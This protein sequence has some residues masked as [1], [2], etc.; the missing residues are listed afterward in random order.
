MRPMRRIFRLALPA[1]LAL[2]VALTGCANDPDPGDVT[3]EWVH[4]EVIHGDTTLVRTLSGSVWGDTMILVPEVVIGELDGADPYV[5][6]NVTSVDRDAQGRIW[7]ADRQ[8]GE[9][10]VF[11]P[12]GD[13]L[14]VVGSRGDGPGEYQEPD[15]LRVTSSDEVVVRDQR[16]GRFVV[17][18]TE[19]AYL[20]SWRLSGNFVTMAPFTLDAQDRIYNP[21]LRWGTDIADENRNVLV[22]IDVATGEALD[23]LSTPRAEA[24]PAFVE[25]RIEEGENRMISRSNVPFYPT[26][27]ASLTADGG[28]LIG[29][30]S[31]YALQL[32]R[33]DGSVL[34][35]ERAIEPVPV[36]PAEASAARSR[37]ERGFR[38]Q[39]AGWRWNGPEIPDV[40]PPF[41]WA[42]MGPDG[43]I[44]AL[45]HTLGREVDN[46]DWDPEAP[47][48]REQPRTIWEE[49]SVMDVFDADGR[50]LGPV[51]M[52]DGFTPQVE[53]V[54]T[55]DE[56]LLRV[57]EPE[58]G[59]HQVVR[60]RIAPRAEAERGG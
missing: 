20:R 12:D 43:S 45:R 38:Q 51:R 18:S 44:W 26:G 31:R 54:F 42:G 21:D 4:E 46:P 14:Q 34:A 30:G 52:P 32:E 37:I 49:D 35:I 11:G 17:F 41:R 58:L 13:F 3:A 50:Y 48:A 56:V 6:G 27:T 5:F 39:D 22:Q 55:A 1:A 16:G 9:V 8:A 2:S 47:P 7:V 10:R 36:L 19:G 23:T 57:A 25:L 53:G 40:K 29:L 24:S 28:T 15:F 33:P 59:Y 60:Y